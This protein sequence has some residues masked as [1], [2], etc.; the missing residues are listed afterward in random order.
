MK[1]SSEVLIISDLAYVVSQWLNA[2]KTRTDLFRINCYNTIFTT[3]FQG[4][5]LTY[6]AL[7]TKIYSLK[8]TSE[9][10]LVVQPNI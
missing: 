2:S 9:E 5:C 3:Y 8:R 6:N 1:V 7:L 10:E 4:R